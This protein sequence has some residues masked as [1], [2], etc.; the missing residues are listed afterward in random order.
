MEIDASAGDATEGRS[1]CR[2]S[3]APQQGQRMMSRPSGRRIQSAAV[4]GWSP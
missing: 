4:W 1:S 2:C 3:V